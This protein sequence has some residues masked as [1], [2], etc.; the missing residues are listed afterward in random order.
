MHHFA[1]FAL[2]E[3]FDPA[4]FL[5]TTTVP[6]DGSWRKGNVHPVTSGV[7]QVLGDGWTTPWPDQERIAIGFLAEHRDGLRA[8]AA[9][10][11]VTTV[12]LGLHYH[13]EKGQREFCLSPSAQLM[14]HVLD[15]GV[16][17]FLYTTYG[18]RR[19]WED[20]PRWDQPAP[21]RPA[22]ADAAMPVL[23]SSA[24]LLDAPESEEERH[25]AMTEVS[26]GLMHAVWR[27]AATRPDCVSVNG[28]SYHYLGEEYENAARCSRCGAWATDTDRPGWIDCIRHGSI[29]EGRF[30]CEPCRVRLIHAGVLPDPARPGAAP[31]SAN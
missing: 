11:G 29:I 3:S 2:G 13:A 22:A 12:A 14:R 1:L 30:L 24:V 16:Q 6:F 8:L 5:A 25:A 18:I 19:P 10:P 15:A 23:V 27:F 21:P 4:P 28:T 7:R 9:F 17:L 31:D 26:Q 20:E